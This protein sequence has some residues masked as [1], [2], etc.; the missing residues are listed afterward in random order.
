MPERRTRGP[1]AHQIGPSPSQTRTGVQANGWPAATTWVR[2]SRIDIGQA[3]ANLRKLARGSTGWRGG[4]A[5]RRTRRLRPNGGA[6]LYLN[7]RSIDRLDRGD[8]GLGAPGS[9]ENLV[10]VDLDPGSLQ[11]PDQ[12][13]FP[14]LSGIEGGVDDSG[15]I[16]R[17]LHVAALQ[18]QYMASA[19]CPD[20]VAEF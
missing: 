5:S 15:K 13:Q 14:A 9:G 3:S 2:K 16:R 6:D 4:K 17:K 20:E 1:S 11:L 12:L 19:K 7:Q 8:D 10:H 18:R